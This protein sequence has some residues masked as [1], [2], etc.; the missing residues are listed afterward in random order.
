MSDSS[1]SL[2]GLAA[3][4][5]IVTQGYYAANDGGAATFAV[6]SGSTA[7]GVF[8]HTLYGYSGLIAELVIQDGVVNVDQL[9]ANGNAV[10]PSSYDDVVT[11]QSE[12]N[13][14]TNATINA[15][16]N[17]FDNASVLA[18]ACQS[19]RVR[20]IRLTPGKIY[21]V[22]SSV[23]ISSDHIL[24]GCGATIM[25]LQ[26]QTAVTVF[27]CTGTAAQYVK[28]VKLHSFRLIGNFLFGGTGAQGVFIQYGKNIHIHGVEIERCN[29]GIHVT[30]DKSNILSGHANQVDIDYIQIHDVLMGIQYNVVHNGSITHSSISADYTFLGAASNRNHCIYADESTQNCLFES[31]ELSRANGGNG[32]NVKGTIDPSRNLVIQNIYSD[33]VHK[34][35]GLVNVKNAVVRNVYATNVGETGINLLNAQIISISDSSFTGNAEHTAGSGFSIAADSDESVQFENESVQNITIRNCKFEFPW[36]F[37][38]ISQN[39]YGNCSNIQVSGCNFKISSPQTDQKFVP[40]YIKGIVSDIRFFRCRFETDGLRR[41]ITANA[42]CS[43]ILTAYWQNRMM[44]MFRL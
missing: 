6:K 12:C 2:T 8:T 21:G 44:K 32:I 37:L 33:T 19:T 20:E 26:K 18:A 24:N 5:Q 11:T 10:L 28:N 35:I 38:T 7:D 39:R 42:A 43:F 30:L 1:F 23:S 15:N 9:G 17:A 40:A 13:T 41:R 25:N 14:R 34:V 22:K 3:G 4:D 16:N 31:L 27:S 36:H 29:F